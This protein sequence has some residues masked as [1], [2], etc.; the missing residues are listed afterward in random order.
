MS[1]SD[2]RAPVPDPGRIGED[3]LDRLL[4]AVARGEHGAFDVVY[5]Q[6]SGPIYGIIQTLVNNNVRY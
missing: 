1:E 6:L 3:D 5:E 4:A 2:N